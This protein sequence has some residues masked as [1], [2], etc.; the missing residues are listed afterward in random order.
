MPF[1]AAQEF[2]VHHIRLGKSAGIPDNRHDFQ[3]ER[4]QEKLP[5]VYGSFDPRIGTKTG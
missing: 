4:Q 1:L 5:T 3:G 2:V